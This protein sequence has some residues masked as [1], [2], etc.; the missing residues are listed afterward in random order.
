MIRAMTAALAHLRSAVSPF[1]VTTLVGLALL[2][3]IRDRQLG[4]GGCAA[5]R[6][7]I[8]T[9]L[10]GGGRRRAP[11]ISDNERGGATE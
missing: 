3:Q 7:R 2:A 8:L 9:S 11:T 1:C 6:A 4:D 5:G 10:F